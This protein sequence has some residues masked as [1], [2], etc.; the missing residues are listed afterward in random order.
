MLRKSLL[1]SRN[2]KFKIVEEIRKV[3]LANKERLAKMGVETRMG[4]YEDKILKNEIAT[5]YSP[6]PEYLELLH[7]QMKRDC[8]NRR[9]S[10]GVIRQSLDDKPCPD[11]NKQYHLHDFSE[12]HSISSASSA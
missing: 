4:K 2:I 12:F 11:N 5:L 9:R 10:F 7:I 6:G 3:S 8:H 1:R